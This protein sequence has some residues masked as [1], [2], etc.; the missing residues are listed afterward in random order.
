M[1]LRCASGPGTLQPPSPPPPPHPFRTVAAP[2][3]E[4]AQTFCAERFTSL[5][6]D[7]GVRASCA[8][9]AIVPC[10][11]H[12]VQLPDRVQVPHGVSV[13]EQNITK[14]DIGGAICEFADDCKAAA[15]IVTASSRQ[16]RVRFVLG[17]TIEYVINRCQRSVIL[18]HGK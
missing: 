10:H 11:Q 6:E 5:L 8:E 3:V 2:Q 13:V 14:A 16:G 7:S 9:L 18:S 4:Q 17:P 15:V 12:P 1:L